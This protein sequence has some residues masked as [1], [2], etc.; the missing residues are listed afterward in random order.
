MIFQRS[1]PLTALKREKFPVRAV[2]RESNITRPV[3]YFSVAARQVKQA[4]WLQKSGCA[5]NFECE[6]TVP[7]QTNEMAISCARICYVFL[8][9]FCGDLTPLCDTSHA[10]FVLVIVSNL[11]LLNFERLL[12]RKKVYQCVPPVFLSSF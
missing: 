3:R 7:T 2:K 11:Q 8:A 12:Q 5:C 6:N 10:H 9:R 1:A 4:K